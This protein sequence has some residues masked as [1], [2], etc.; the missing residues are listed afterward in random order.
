M[1][2]SGP[3]T[4]M[5]STTIDTEE[6]ELDLEAVIAR[7]AG[8]DSRVSHA[9]P[10]SLSPEHRQ[11]AKKLVLLHTE[12]RCESYGF[13]PERQLH[14]FKKIK[15]VR[16]VRTRVKNTFIDAWLEGGDC[17]LF[18]SPMCS[19]MFRSLPS[20]WR[21]GAGVAPDKCEDVQDVAAL[22]SPISD[23]CESV[24]DITQ[25]CATPSPCNSPK[26]ADGSKVRLPWHKRLGDVVCA[27]ITPMS[28]NCEESMPDLTHMC[29]TPSP[30]NSPQQADMQKARLLTEV[31][32]PT[33][34]EFA[35]SD[36]HTPPSDHGGAPLMCMGLLMPPP[37]SPANV[38]LLAEGTAV[39][40][41]GLLQ[42]PD[43]N[44][45]AG[46][47][48]S[49]DPILRRYNVLLDCSSDG[50]CGPRNVKAKRENLRLRT[51]PPPSSAAA[52]L[53]TNIM[54][55]S[56]IPLVTEDVFPCGGG[57]LATLD[58]ASQ[59]PSMAP[60]SPGWFPWQFCESDVSP[61][62]WHD[63]TNVED[64][65][66]GSPSVEQFAGQGATWDYSG[67]MLASNEMISAFDAPDGA[68]WQQHICDAGMTQ[69]GWS[70]PNYS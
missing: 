1:A 27:L 57:D 35:T 21:D 69:A 65:S 61:T 12:L 13:G 46:I 22:V 28:D 4:A 53:A 11:L 42:R 23:N 68:A 37:V 63:R 3:L 20:D 10:A 44:G 50:C 24:Q 67:G 25:V 48:Q 39:E 5:A 60:D 70:Q 56:C 36:E 17:K 33:R 38:M 43:F 58:V 66:M 51:P 45:K 30:C 18:G 54:L 34:T 47:V 19:P 52:I 40:I 15:G 31:C 59:S 8:D 14:L 64:Q 16:G 41:D 29:S 55:D 26:H 62:G 49:W 9:L 7:F 2:P 6:G 32:D